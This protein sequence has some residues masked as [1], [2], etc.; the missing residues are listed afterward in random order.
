MNGY[1]WD[2]I[3][4]A[5]VTNPHSHPYT[6]IEKVARRAQIPSPAPSFEPVTPLYR[7]GI[8]RWIVLSVARKSQILRER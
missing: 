2:A 4:A 7:Y 1:K 5:F 3:S 6:P 8:S